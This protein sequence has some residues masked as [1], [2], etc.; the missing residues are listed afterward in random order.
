MINPMTLELSA[1]CTLQ[2]TQDLN[3]CLLLCKIL[4]KIQWTTSFLT[5][6]LHTEFCHQKF[7]EFRLLK[8]KYDYK[9]LWI[10]QQQ[11]PQQ[12]TDGTEHP[13]NGVWQGTAV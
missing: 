3:G 7:K 6:T 12:E 10:L 13:F 2:N 9:P 11:E 8:I 5:V 1:Q 4:G